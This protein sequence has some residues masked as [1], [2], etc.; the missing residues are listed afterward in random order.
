[1]AETEA[2]ACEVAVTMNPFVAGKTAGGVY[3]PAELIVPIKEF[4][5]STPFT[6]QFTGVAGPVAVNVCDVPRATFALPGVT[7]SAEGV[8][9][10][11]GE[12][13]G[14]GVGLGVGV[15]T[16][17]GVGVA[18]GVGVGVGLEFACALLPLL[19]PPTLPHATMPK[20]ALTMSIPNILRCTALKLDREVTPVFRFLR[21]NSFTTIMT[22]V[23]LPEAVTLEN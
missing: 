21:T 3:T 10:G 23:L 4:P 1:V 14:V 18:D 15:E 22:T 9:V 7:I 6:L 16:G 11:L 20:R 12:A 19:L 8:G 5:P 13:I 2:F 17:V